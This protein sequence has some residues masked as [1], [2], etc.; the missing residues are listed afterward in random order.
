M[1]KLKSLFI[2]LGLGVVAL[3]AQAG[4]K[5]DMRGM[6]GA[7]KALAASTTAEQ[8]VAAADQFVAS[9]TS[10]QN[11]LPADFNANDAKAVEGYKKGLQDVINTANEGKKLAAEGKLAEAK[12]L[13]AQLE[14]LK[15]VNHKLYK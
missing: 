5:E 7:V 1:L 3:S 4:L 13:L 15:N 9:A 6:L 10:A 2:A 11:T 12:A 8:Y 14:E